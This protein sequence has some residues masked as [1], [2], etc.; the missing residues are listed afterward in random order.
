MGRIIALP[1]TVKEKRNEVILDPRSDFRNLV[2][3]YMGSEAAHLY[4][5]ILEELEEEIDTQ[6]EYGE[7]HL[8]GDDYGIISKA[9]LRQLQDV[10]HDLEDVVSEKSLNRDRLEKIITSLDGIL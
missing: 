5:D 2:E 3:E 6:Y 10:L 4:D 9:S 1:C 8:Y 7:R